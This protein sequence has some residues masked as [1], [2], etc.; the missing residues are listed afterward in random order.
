MALYGV[1]IFIGG[2]IQLAQPALGN[3][4]HGLPGSE[5]DLWFARFI[6]LLMIALAILL[7]A[8][9][10]EV[11]DKPFRSATLAFIGVNAIIA[12]S[13]YQAPGIHTTGRDIST[14]I[15]GFVAFL[16][17]ITLPIKPIGYKENLAAQ[18]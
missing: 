15:F 5:S 2:A 12:T 18:S 17:V 3:E 11:P 8:T 1:G 16:F 6:G 4:F 10:R 13:I 14:G 9:S 7:S